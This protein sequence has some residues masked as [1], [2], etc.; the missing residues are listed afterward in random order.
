[1]AICDFLEEYYNSINNVR[2]KIEFREWPIRVNEK[3]PVQETGTECGPMLIRG[4]LDFAFTG[5]SNDWSEQETIYLRKW[6]AAVIQ[7]WT[8]G[9]DVN[10]K[11][12]L[13][14]KVNSNS[15]VEYEQQEVFVN[16]QTT[17]VKSKTC[18]A[19][20]FQ[21]SSLQ[22]ES[23][24][25][26]LLSMPLV[27]LLK[28]SILSRILIARSN[29]E[30]HTDYIKHIEWFVD[31]CN[32]WPNNV[33][34]QVPDLKKQ[35]L[36][37]VLQ[38]DFCFPT[39]NL[40]TDLGMAL[41][42]F[43]TRC[44][45]NKN[46]CMLVLIN[47]LMECQIEWK[48]SDSKERKTFIALKAER[49][50]SIEIE[51]VFSFHRVRNHCCRAW[52]VVYGVHSK[53]LKKCLENRVKILP[54]RSEKWKHSV[55][56]LSL[57]Q[58]NEV[59][60]HLQFTLLPNPF[61]P[62]GLRTNQYVLPP[63]LTSFHQLYWDY[64][65]NHISDCKE[66][67]KNQR[68]LNN[69]I[70]V[71]YKRKLDFDEVPAKKQ[72]IHISSKGFSVQSTF[73]KSG[74]YKQVEHA[75][76][77]HAQF[78]SCVVHYGSWYKHFNRIWNSQ[79]SSTAFGKTWCIL[80]Q[81]FIDESTKWHRFKNNQTNETKKSAKYYDQKQIWKATKKAWKL[82]YNHAQ[83]ERLHH[84]L[85]RDR[86][87]DGKIRLICFDFKTSLVSPYWGYH[88]APNNVYFMSRMN[89]YFFGI[90]DEGKPDH[91][92]GFVYP[93]NYVDSEGPGATKKGS[94]HVIAMLYNF[95]QKSNL[96]DTNRTN[97][98]TLYFAADNCSGQNKN[99]FVIMFFCLSVEL[100]WADDIYLDFMIP[101]HT[102]FGPDRWFGKIGKQ[103]IKLD[104][105]NTEEI[106]NNIRN[107][108]AYQ[109]RVEDLRSQ[110]CRNFKPFLNKHYKKPTFKTSEQY[111]FWF[112]AK[113]RGSVRI[114]VKND[115]SWS[116]LM[117]LRKNTGSIIFNY[118]NLPTFFIA[119]LTTQRINVFREI[120]R[121]IPHV[122]AKLDYE[123]KWEEWERISRDWDVKGILK[124]RN[125]NG[126]TQYKVKFKDDK[127]NKWSDDKYD[128]WLTEEQLDGSQDVL[129][130]FN[131][132]HK[133]P[134]TLT[135]KAFHGFDKEK[136]TALVEWNKYP[137]AKDW[138]WEN[139]LILSPDDIQLLE[140]YKKVSNC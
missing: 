106:V 21:T 94:S 95:M 53:N 120:K 88:C 134:S 26:R 17:P 54:E 136:E 125:I 127:Y 77:L 113:H 140:D 91:F 44:C 101:G 49:T 56:Q 57:A 78:C 45:I 4:A 1:M 96:T 20:I 2:K 71:G 13:V 98:R 118:N 112:S 15:P 70:T 5:G 38:N 109:E 93:E 126:V 122:E 42:C 75:T 79:V 68:K 67:Q 33:L 114:K 105:W 104:A 8:Y 116:D 117:P 29:G 40:R 133:T 64:V 10:L 19:S 137:A 48:A 108:L 110:D 62:K 46:R 7:E 11:Q 102:K 123:D 66:F 12:L 128:E 65:W 18:M 100:G 73:I 22:N 129:S 74:V 87:A 72:K 32:D 60:N 135:V 6:F 16:R 25:N 82:H 111:H 51:E 34:R 124:S 130:A 103:I 121:L 139:I 3:F 99:R 115:D 107:S 132:K 9:R 36:V 80:C 35:Y 92:T 47:D 76:D 97:D 24:I 43:S 58:I 52:Q 50:I 119:P 39:G 89:A 28:L 138:T 69:T 23:A 84:E 31:H 83:A 90:V 27:D 59:D 30:A 37:L 63:N 14:S 61:T 131:E 85:L 41:L 55:K 81:T 86:A